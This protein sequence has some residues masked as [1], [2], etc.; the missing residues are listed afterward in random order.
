MP[1]QAQNKNP[2]QWTPVWRNAKCD[3]GTNRPTEIIVYNFAQR[4]YAKGTTVML[5]QLGG[6]P[7]NICW[8]VI[9]FGADPETPV[10]Q[11]FEGRWDF[12]SLLANGN[13]FFRKF[14]PDVPEPLSQNYETFTSDQYETEFRQDYY[15]GLYTSLTSPE[16]SGDYERN[17]IFD[18]NTPRALNFGVN[19]EGYTQITSWDFLHN[20]IGGTRGTHNSIGTTIAELHPSGVTWAEEVAARGG[21]STFEDPST[22]HGFSAAPFFGPV[23]PDRYEIGPITGEDGAVDYRSHNVK[24]QA[25]GEGKNLWDTTSSPASP[26][27]NSLCSYIYKTYEKGIFDNKLVNDGGLMIPADVALHSS[28]NGEN[29]RPISNIKWIQEHMTLG[30][31]NTDEYFSVFPDGP[32]PTLDVGHPKRYSWLARITQENGVNVANE[33]W[34]LA[35]KSR[36]VQFRPLLAETYLTFGPTN[37]GAVIPGA[38]GYEFLKNIL[39]MAERGIVHQTPPNPVLGDLA[40]D[41]A[42]PSFKAHHDSA[43]LY[44]APNVGSIG[45][46]DYNYGFPIGVHAKFG[47]SPWTN[48]TAGTYNREIWGTSNTARAGNPNAIGITSAIFTIKS[49]GKDS[50]SFQAEYRI[51]VPA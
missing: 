46:G 16:A 34:D 51:G 37:W 20:S 17:I 19:G 21:D 30:S 42:P 14:K 49:D 29:G 31:I 2:N 12:T 44:G 40:Y 33:S 6:S 28:P 35:P 15:V 39:H 11:T 23:F 25:L 5:N 43:S 8:A 41:R 9:D 47:N 4:T 18:G 48:Y 7:P 45:P 50:I 24:F 13:G 38:N 26:F 3:D 36:R 27:G 22:K 10:S 32:T 1:L